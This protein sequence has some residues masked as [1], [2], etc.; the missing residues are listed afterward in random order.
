MTEFQ[1]DSVLKCLTVVIIVLFI[2]I[3]VAP[4]MFLDWL[5]ILKLIIILWIC[6]HHVKGQNSTFGKI[7]KQF[8]DIIGIRPCLHVI[9]SVQLTG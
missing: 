9:V 8:V 1:Q 5:N 6:V 2:K 7:L 4:L 3:L